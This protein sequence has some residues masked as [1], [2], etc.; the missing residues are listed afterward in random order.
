MSKSGYR[1]NRTLN[2]S[3]YFNEAR[4]INGYEYITKTPNGDKIMYH[5]NSLRALISQFKFT[6]FCL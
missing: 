6:P 2:I 3:I 4:G 5:L 1:T